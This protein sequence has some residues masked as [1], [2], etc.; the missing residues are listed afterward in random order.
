MTIKK[1]AQVATV[2]SLD[3]GLAIVQA[4]ANSQQPMS[5][6]Q[7][8]ELMSV[9][10]STAFR[11]LHTLK[12]RGFLTMPAGRKDYI[13]GSA[14]W[15][16][17]NH[18]DWSKMLV[19]VASGQLKELAA[20]TNETAHIAIREGSQALF[21]DC[22]AASHMVAVSSRIGE[23]LPLYCTA[24]GKALL[25]DASE[26]ELKKMYGNRP[27]RK[28]TESTLSTVPELMNDIAGIKKRGYAVDNA[29]FRDEIR[30]IAAPIRLNQDIVGSIGISAPVLRVTK[31]NTLLNVEHVC[32]VA[33]RIGEILSNLEA[34]E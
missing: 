18:Y 32:T 21:M 5:L 9:D 14:I 12:R 27:L 15:T 2:Q 23:L 13:L 22:A 3:R 30:C 17:Y 29:E 24:H 10:R 20:Q 4:I 33:T 6:G 7:V 11:L 34:E 19:K 26:Q 31:K 1:P 8:A 16:L 25:A 28:L